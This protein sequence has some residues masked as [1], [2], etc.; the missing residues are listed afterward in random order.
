MLRY[1]LCLD[2]ATPKMNKDCKNKIED[3]LDRY[4]IKPIVVIIPDS[5]DLL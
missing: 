4:D 2:D 1:I 5:A 3:F